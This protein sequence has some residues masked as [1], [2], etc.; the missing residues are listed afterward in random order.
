MQHYHHKISYSL[1]KLGHS[2]RATLNVNIVRGLYLSMIKLID[3]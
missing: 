2:E 3:S 1:M